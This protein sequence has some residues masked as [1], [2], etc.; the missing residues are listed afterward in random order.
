M[1]HPP[2][3][4]NPDIE[5]DVPDEVTQFLTDLNRALL[6][7]DQVEAHALYETQYPQLT[8]TF[9]TNKAPRGQ[10][11]PFRTWPNLKFVKQCFTH[12]TTE[13]LYQMLFA[14]HLFTD[15]NVSANVRIKS[16]ETFSELFQVLMEPNPA[17]DLPNGWLWDILDEYMFQLQTHHN[18]RLRNESNFPS[19]V[20]NI[21]AVTEKLAEIVKKSD[22]LNVLKQVSTGKMQ[23]ADFF[24]S[25]KDHVR[26]T[27]GLF[28]II[29]QMRL[30]V[31]VG[32]YNG[33]LAAIEPL[34][35]FTTGRLITQ[36]AAPAHVA[37]FYNLGFS[38]LMLRRY[39][40]AAS[41][42]K[43][44][45]SVKAVNRT[46][47][48]ALQA[49]VVSLMSISATLGCLPS[50]DF[51][52]FL[53]EKARSMQEDDAQLLGQGD[54]DRFRDVFLK[55]CPKFISI[56]DPNSTTYQEFTGQEGKELQLRV[57]M[58]AVQQQ[59]DA[60]RL[61]GYLRVYSTINGS[62]IESLM[63]S[64][65]TPHSAYAHLACLKRKSVERV[66]DGSSSD[67]LSG[68]LKSTAAIDFVVNMDKV[69]VI[70]RREQVSVSKRFV[71]LL[72][73]L[74]S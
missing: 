43:L 9:F 17:V 45:M 63:G 64:S 61:R 58:R 2:R 53:T 27:L 18:R 52:A 51:S 54:L 29:T 74:Q 23:P 72:E 7:K 25:D 16:W 73:Q 13:L 31:A 11:L 71:A 40:D 41:T 35:V 59:V 20:W 47:V 49:Q 44:A 48:D 4:T 36:R 10:V 15:R 55:A 65:A 21:S 1:A 3:A 56:V 32:D 46:Y 57:F 68:S 38:Y 30:S 37:L 60:L 39:T 34:Q 8:H 50:E 22:V 24:V 42:L 19:G 67:P 14:R 69:S 33:A 28:A 6:A 70:H 5:G 12:P 62:K 66:H 26:R